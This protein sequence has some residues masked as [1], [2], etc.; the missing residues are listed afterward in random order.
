M[1]RL[2][3]SAEKAGIP[4]SE[5]KKN[6]EAREQE[7]RKMLFEQSELGLSPNLLDS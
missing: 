6:P 3:S 5:R 7:I 4:L 2:I 1:D